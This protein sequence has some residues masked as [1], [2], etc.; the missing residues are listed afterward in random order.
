MYYRYP[1]GLNFVMF[2]VLITLFI[3]SGCVRESWPPKKAPL[4]TRWAA[5]VSPE[6]VHPEY[7]RPQMVRE[8][9][10]NLNGLWQF[11]VADSNDLPSFGSD[12]SG[13][14]LVPFAMESALSGVMQS[15]A[16]SYYRRMAI[17]PE[18]WKGQRILLHFGAVD[19]QT[20]VWVNGKEVGQHRGGYDPFTFDITD[21]LKPSGQQEIIVKVYDPTNTKAIA[22]G[23]QV[24]KPGGI[25]YTPVSGIWQTVWL[26]PV[27]ENYIAKI[28]LYPDI[29]KQILSIDVSVNR[30]TAGMHLRIAALKEN[31]SLAKA[32]G[33]VGETI[34][35][36][37]ANAELWSPDN[38]VLYDLDVRLLDGDRE[39]DRVVAYFGMRKISL[40]KDAGGITRIALNNKEMFQLGPLDQGYWPDGL[41]TAPTDEAL[42]YDI[43]I[44]KKLGFNMIR[45]HVKVEPARWYYWCDKMGMVVWQDMPSVYYEEFERGRTTESAQQF[46]N[47]LTALINGLQP[48]PSIVM[49]VVFNESWGQYDTARLTAFVKAMDPTRLVNNASGWTDKKVGDVNDIHRYPGPGAPLPEENRAAVLGEFGGLGL[50]VEGHTWQQENW[51]YLNLTSRNDLKDR[52][53]RLM[54]GVWQLKNDPGLSA[55]VYTQ[56]TDVE[57]ETNGLLT[58]DRAVIKMDMDVARSFHL[59]NMVSLP[60]IKPGGGLF[61]EQ[62]TV[63]IV[64]RKGE[65]IRYTTDGS[66]PDGNATLY[67]GKFTLQENCVVKAHSVSADGRRSGLTSVEFVKTTLRPAETVTKAHKAGL[68]Y[69]YY[70]GAWNGLPDFDTL[71]VKQAGI[72]DQFTLA[73]KKRDDLFGF[74]FSGYLR[75]DHPGIYTFFTESDD[76]SK[77]YIGDHL[78]VDNDDF[79]AMKERSGQIALAAGWHP[80]TVTFFEGTINEGLIVRYQGPGVLKQEI[81]ASRL[82]HTE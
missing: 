62:T 34:I 37:L 21:A 13:K 26:E 22:T 18:N 79:H 50:P 59:D 12:L 41:Y 29:D 15:A 73:Q 20:T 48:F 35:L 72:S 64:N 61:L 27:A 55:A 19:W 76:G 52:Y 63:E 38:P 70:E 17:L 44:A 43:K 80:I 66:E 36:P 30:G 58:Y 28:Q 74:H 65:E 75:I 23:K 24:Q 14:I 9:W 57:T 71:Q 39:V 77:L 53:E 2:F 4:M 56:I 1:L 32:K 81:P 6:S 10:L 46:E 82:F 33:K 68:R 11:T 49:W 47:E 40:V 69:R 67:K 78:V 60:E 54:D 7:P 31:N 25:F 3:T 16:H 51:G 8:N 42:R 45:K 5:D